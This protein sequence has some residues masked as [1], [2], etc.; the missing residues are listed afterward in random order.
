M[1]LDLGRNVV[2]DQL[3]NL[4][5]FRRLSHGEIVDQDFYLE[6]FFVNSVK[7]LTAQ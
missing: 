4:K 7:F 5:E 6:M 2:N 3:N 1:Y